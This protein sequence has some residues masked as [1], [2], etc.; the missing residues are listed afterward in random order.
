MKRKLFI[1]FIQAVIVLPIFS[2]LLCMLGVPIGILIA[3]LKEGIFSLDSLNVESIYESLVYA[4]KV[5]GGIGLVLGGG[6]LIANVI[7]PMAK[8]KFDNNV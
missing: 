5:G 2:I 6:L 7:I 8:G 1:S 3:F 4:I